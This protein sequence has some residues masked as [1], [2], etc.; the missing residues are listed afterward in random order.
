MT[1]L[2]EVR[3]VVEGL[4]GQVSGVSDFK[5]S[6]SEAHESI[7]QNELR[8]EV[9]VRPVLPLTYFKLSFDAAPLML[10]LFNEW[11]CCRFGTNQ[12]LEDYMMEY[13]GALCDV[14]QAEGVSDGE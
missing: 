4:M 5:V 13:L 7:D 11:Y 1:S 3:C 9:L 6:A 10:S 14:V 8:L 12:S 2:E